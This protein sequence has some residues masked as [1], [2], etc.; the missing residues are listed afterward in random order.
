MTMT[1]FICVFVVLFVVAIIAARLQV[2]KE[3][4]SLKQRAEDAEANLGYYKDRCSTQQE[5]CTVL[6]ME[7]DTKEKALHEFTAAAR[8]VQSTI[9]QLRDE[10]HELQAEITDQQATIDKCK[11][12]IKQSIDSLRET[13]MAMVG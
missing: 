1:V 7:L 13:H 2:H 9:T 11:A 4:G 8:M 3:L 6:Q 10:V 12:A 5:K